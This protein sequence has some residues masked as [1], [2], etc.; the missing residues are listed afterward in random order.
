MNI[1]T[2]ILD[3]D[4]RSRKAAQTALEE[5]ADVEIVGQFERSTQLMEYLANQSADLLF[6]DIELKDEFGFSVAERLRGKY[7]Q[8]LVVFLTGHSSYAIDG[9]GFQPVNFLT[10]PINPLKMAQTIGEV[11]RRLAPDGRQRSAKLMFRMQQ[12]YT[13]LDVRDI[14]FVE[15]KE[16]KNILHSA[17]EGEGTRISGYTMRELEE[18]LSPYGFFL[19]HQ[20]FLVSLYRVRILRD[21]G[22]QLY[23]V[24]LQGWDTPVPV[25]R[26]RYEAM[27]Q[28]L[29]NLH[30]PLV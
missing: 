4:P 12:G 10:K 8:L 5:F 23:E 21:V 18:M 17:Q 11:R 28:A 13:I 9:Y 25:S 27:K 14:L 30:I 20:S 15:R 16:R 24:V 22:R 29:E 1:R 2:L 6:L 7:P 26:N 3:D 19:C